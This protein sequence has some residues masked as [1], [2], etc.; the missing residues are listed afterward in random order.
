MQEI[1]D[2]LRRLGLPEY[3]GAFAENGID[4]SVLPH[5]GRHRE[6]PL[7]ILRSGSG[8]FGVKRVRFCA[9]A[10]AARAAG[11]RR[12]NLSKL[13]AFR[14]LFLEGHAF[15]VTALE[16][17]AGNFRRL[18]VEAGKARTIEYP[19]TCLHA[20]SE[21][22]GRSKRGAD[23]EPRL[24]QVLPCLCFVVEGADLNQPLPRGVRLPCIRFDRCRFRFGWFGLT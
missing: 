14:L 16:V 10:A 19:I 6:A 21:W 20:L 24:T 18:L 2:W 9:S 15:E 12:V 17:R 4:V 22:L 11:M 13:P 7:T 3:A 5:L 23:L 1:A 8:Q